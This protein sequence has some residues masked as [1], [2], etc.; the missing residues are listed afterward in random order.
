[1]DSSNG[2]E[3]MIQLLEISCWRPLHLLV[4]GGDSYFLIRKDAGKEV[5][6]ILGNC[7]QLDLCFGSI[8]AGVGR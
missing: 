2:I 8:A 3:A 6:I 7:S 4:S 5:L 1:M